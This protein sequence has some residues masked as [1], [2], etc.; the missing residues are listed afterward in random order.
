M[1]P[2]KCN[3]DPMPHDEAL[4]VHCTIDRGVLFLFKNNYVIINAI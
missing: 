4:D 1:Q 3:I 2:P